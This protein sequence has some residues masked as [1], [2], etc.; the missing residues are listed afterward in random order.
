M[1]VLKKFFV[2]E[3]H[4]GRDGPAFGLLDRLVH[5]A[6]DFRMTDI[7]L[8]TPAI[9]T[10]SHEFYARNGFKPATA[11]DLPMGYLYPDRDS[12]LFRLQLESPS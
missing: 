6:R 7:A 4:R 1:G 2:A 9:A 12:H 10:R 5:R 11:D 3:F 8:D